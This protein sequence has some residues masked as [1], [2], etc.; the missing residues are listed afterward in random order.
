LETLGKAFGLKILLLE[1]GGRI[2]GS[3]LKAG[4]ID[5]ISLLAFP[6]IDGLSGMP[7]IFE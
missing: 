2:N 3:F 4:L 5:E 1:G 6:G 7:T